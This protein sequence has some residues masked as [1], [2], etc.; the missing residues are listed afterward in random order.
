MK[1]PDWLVVARRELLERLRSKWFVAVTLLGPIF[2]IALI[3]LPAVLAGIETKVRVSVVD[4]SGRLASRL[5][6][7]LRAVG[8]SVDEPPVDTPESALLAGIRE[9]R[10]D[11]FVIVPKD[12]LGAGTIVY[13]GD[14]ATNQMVMYTLHTA[15]TTSVQR[16]RGDDLHIDAAQLGQV[17]APVVL[18][19]QHTTGDPH[20]TNGTAAFLLGY[21]V[22]FII[23]LAIVLYGSNVLR[24]VVLEKT[25]RVAEIMIAAAKPHA[26]M[27]GKIVGVGGAGLVQMTVWLVMAALLVANHETVLGW[28]G[29]SGGFTLPPLGAGQVV[30]VLAFF[31]LG[32]FFYAALFAA[33]GAMV[34]S[35]QEAQAA[36]T[37]II[38][39]LIVPMMCLQVVAGDPRGGAAEVLTQIPF[40]SAMLMP[41]RYL[42]GGAGVGEVL[43]AMAVLALTTLLVARLAARIYR[44]GLLAYGKRPSLRELLRWMRH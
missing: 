35:D 2:M 42:L 26:L 19:A 34:S 44:V 38:L 40:F 1:L 28:F 22:M 32:Y 12:G 14:N 43:L 6:P 21:A 8:W 15:L 17:L 7:A 30:V 31:L 36:Q 11:G 16:A 9:N 18:D 20:A 41:L 33:V 13:K 25:N 3:V 37:P 23:Y 10:I 4:H 39:M 27:L 29:A 5:D 24:S